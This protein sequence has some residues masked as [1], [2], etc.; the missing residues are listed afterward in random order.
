[1][2]KHLEYILTVIFAKYEIAPSKSWQHYMEYPP[3]LDLQKDG[4]AQFTRRVTQLK[5]ATIAQLPC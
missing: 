2:T 1:M 5:S 4:Y 3:P